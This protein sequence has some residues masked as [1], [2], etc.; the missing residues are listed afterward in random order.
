MRNLF[1]FLW[2]H[3]F[4]T[5]F[6]VLEVI[7]LSLL[8]TSYSYHKSLS[9][10]LTSDINGGVH[11]SANNITSY[12]SLG[13]KNKIL[14]EE[15][16][17]LRNQQA[18]SFLFTDTNYAFV[19]TLFQF[20]PANVICNSTKRQANNIVVDKGSLH[21]VEKEMGVI[22]HD[23]IVGIV[24]GVSRH[25]STIMSALHHN[26]RISAKIKESG[27]LVNVSWPG[28]DYLFGEVTDIP[29]HIQLQKGDTIISSGN[30]IIFPEGIN[31]GVIE[32]HE[33]R[34]DKNLSSAVLKYCVDFN[35]LHYVYLVK[36]R[37][38]TEIDSLL[39]ETKNE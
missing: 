9:F 34:G 23:G 36:N 18:S 14:L 39:M 6:I 17:M 16:A 32:K 1:L 12:F 3:R 29:S 24:I 28:N 33:L 27:Q 21:G 38:K 10:N 13:G 11:K 22:S 31:I 2:K 25:Y 20:I 19:D 30:S 7:S 4:F 8:S 26:T 15:N 35:N 37:M 5:V